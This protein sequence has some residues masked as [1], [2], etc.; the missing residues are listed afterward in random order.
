ML[1]LT[2]R[3]K[4]RVDAPSAEHF[5]QAAMSSKR[6]EQKKTPPPSVKSRAATRAASHAPD[7]TADSSLS[8]HGGEGWAVILFDDAVH[9]RG[10]VLIQVIKALR[11]SARMAN[12][13]VARVEQ[14]G[15]SAVI[16]TTFTHALH[17]D[18]V[19]REIKLRTKLRKIA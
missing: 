14:C 16:I 11:C 19:L 5:F 7:A 15:Q 3:A 9:F 2:L 13:I 17:V 8:L 18:A 6:E 4:A 12:A 10:E 1:V